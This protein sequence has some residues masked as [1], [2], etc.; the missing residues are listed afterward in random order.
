[1]VSV[2]FI[3][4]KVRG[5]ECCQCSIF[6]RAMKIVITPSG[7]VK[8]EAPCRKILRHVNNLFWKYQQKYISG[9]NQEFP[10]PLPPA[11]YQITLLIRFSES[12]GGRIRYFPLLPYHHGSP[13]SF[14]TWEMNNRPL[15]RR[16]SET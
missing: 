10:S 14:I 11:R 4:P 8:P 13:C 15:G 5:F 6:L 1:M 7:E 9:P 2:L 12:S 3:E 16:S